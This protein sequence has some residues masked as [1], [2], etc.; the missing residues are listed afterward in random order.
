MAKEIK[1]LNEK[2]VMAEAVCDKMK[3][4]NW[5]LKNKQ[6][7][8]AN[9]WA[10]AH[11][12][13]RKLLD[14]K[15][16]ELERARETVEAQAK[17]WEIAWQ[18]PSELE[19][20]RKELEDTRRA[21]SLKEAD[22]AQLENSNSRLNDELAAVMS[23][24]RWLLKEGIPLVMEAVRDSKEMCDAV[25]K[26]NKFSNLL[27]Y[28]QGLNEGW[29]LRAAGRAVSGAK[30]YDPEA[31]AKLDAASNSFEDVEFDV[32]SSVVALDEVPVGELQG[33][34]DVAL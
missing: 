23:E 28:Q 29:K 15:K 14:S 34:L 33:A 1:E 2:L 31:Q 32:L 17:D 27:G 9:A 30:Y 4:D 25:T 19:T 16:F 18:A 21:L 20:L 24:R 11:E 5:Q 12:K 7:V 22:F 10:I 26:I 13:A 8:D 3:S 6:I